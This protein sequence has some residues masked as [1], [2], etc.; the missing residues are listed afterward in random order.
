MKSKQSPRV[1]ES[2][3]KFQ[4]NVNYSAVVARLLTTVPDQYLT[5][6]DSIVVCDLAGQTRK[7]RTGTLPSRGR[8]V[9]RDRVAGLY[10]SAY[11]GNRAWVQLFAD[12][13][14]LPPRYLHWVPLVLDF[15]IGDV[16]YHEL[17][18]H[19]HT[20]RPEHREKEDVAEAWQRR[21]LIRHLKHR[22]WYAYPFFWC[23]T[24]VCR[25]IMAYDKIRRS[26]KECLRD[27]KV[28]T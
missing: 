3:T 14:S 24:R 1:V 5:G 12:N 17:G 23:F 2:F 8:K 27:K 7:H 16:L 26:A 28:G 20:L 11:S 15:Y 6:L 10:H 13:I 4:P 22:Y 19:V 9:R 25:V 21:F 18:H